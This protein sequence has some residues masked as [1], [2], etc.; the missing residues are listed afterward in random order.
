VLTNLAGVGVGSNDFGG[1]PVAVACSVTGA[2]APTT[3]RPVTGKPATARF[4]SD[5]CANDHCPRRSVKHRPATCPSVIAVVDRVGNVL[6]VSD[7]KGSN[8]FQ[9][10]SRS[11]NRQIGAGESGNAIGLQARWSRLPQRLSPRRDRSYPVQRRQ[12]FSSRTASQLPRK[13]F[14]SRRPTTV[15]LESGGRWFGV[16]L[17]SCPAR[18]CPSAFSFD[19]RLWES[20]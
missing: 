14:P 17:A 15:G 3:G 9:A 5:R 13:H 7:M 18:T 16:Q 19:G 12:R 11:G 1:T 8:R 2:S 20:L 10:K 4:D 6:A